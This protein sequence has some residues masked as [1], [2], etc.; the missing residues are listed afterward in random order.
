MQVE[1][2]KRMKNEVPVACCHAVFT[3]EERIEY[4][5]AWGE[6]EKRRMAVIEI[7]A[8]F[9]YQFPGDSERLRLLY[10]RISLERCCCPF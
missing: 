10:D 6:L 8:G 7:E 2:A 4:K 3:K 5:D 1:G 9:S